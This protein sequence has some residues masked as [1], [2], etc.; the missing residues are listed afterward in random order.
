[1]TDKQEAAAAPTVAPQRHDREAGHLKVGTMGVLGAAVMAIALI[2][3]LTTFSSNMAESLILGAGG[4]TIVVTVLL[5]GLLLLFT[6]GYV[7]LG[8]HVVDS[9]AYAAYAAHGLGRR[10]GGAISILA[11]LGYNFATVAFVGISGYFFDRTLTAVGLDLPWWC[12]S[13]VVLLVTSAFGVIGLGVASRVNTAICVLQFLMLA[14][15]FGAV[16]VAVPDQFDA[17]V[18]SLDEVTPGAF[19][20][21]VV[22]VLLAL[23]GFES[24]AAYG[25]EVRDPA[26]TIPRA[27]YLTLLLLG[28]VF[29]AG[30]W[31]IVAGSNGDPDAIAQ[32]D[33]GALVPALYGLYL[34]EWTTVATNLIIAI[35]IIG[36]CIAFQNLASRYMFSAARAGLLPARLDRTHPRFG[37]PHVAV[38]AQAVITIALLLPF[39]LTGANP[40]TDLLPAIA[41][42]NAL[43]MMVKMS[44]CSLSVVV[45][46]LRG[47]VSGTVYSTRV[48]PILSLIGFATVSTLIVSHYGDITGTDAAWVNAMPAL[49]VASALVG[50]LMQWHVDRTEAKLP[51]EREE[52]KAS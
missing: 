47:T 8:R 52:L 43:S 31:V 24:S 39:I 25:E 18:F 50:G 38:L 19:G 29:A 42:Y 15:F 23:A 30:T 41:G 35:T 2:T 27:T 37:T 11:A 22:F 3:P 46:S 28:G 32:G 9:G 10:A 17:D 6:A 34:G 21:S 45:A 7:V 1:M 51:V 4:A 33:P 26:R 12:Y 20:L 44:A 5:V 49:I 48:A 36:A 40:M 16:V 13:V 14:I